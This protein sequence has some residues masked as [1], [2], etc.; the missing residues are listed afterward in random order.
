MPWLAPLTAPDSWLGISRQ[1]HKGDGACVLSTARAM[2]RIC[3]QMPL[4]ARMTQGPGGLE[5]GLN[6][7]CT[8]QPW[9]LQGAEKQGQAGA[10]SG[11]RTD[12]L[13][14]NSSHQVLS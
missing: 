4:A 6:E 5:F 1:G 13:E 14:A 12:R 7:P 11:F 2:I 10:F 9:P 8:Q 3:A